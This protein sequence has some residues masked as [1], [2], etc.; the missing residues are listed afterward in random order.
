MVGSPAG[1]RD[2]TANRYIV[3][4][5]V[6][7]V[8]Y[9]YWLSQEARIEILAYGEYDYLILNK[10]IEQAVSELKSIICAS[11][12]RRDR[13]HGLAEKILASFQEAPKRR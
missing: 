3:A 11:R 9:R 8:G 2:V 10:D 4:G 7:G 13:R 12:C 5:R 1:E 6:Q